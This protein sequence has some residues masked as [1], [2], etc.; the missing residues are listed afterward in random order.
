MPFRTYPQ[1]WTY[2]GAVGEEMLRAM[3]ARVEGQCYRCKN[4]VCLVR[5]C[6]SRLLVAVK[7]K[8]RGELFV[9]G[10]WREYENCPHFRQRDWEWDGEPR[11]REY[12]SDALACLMAERVSLFE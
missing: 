4:S 5:C 3:S 9:Y 10:R 7:C 2:P 6:S 1:E 8:E 11:I 12:S